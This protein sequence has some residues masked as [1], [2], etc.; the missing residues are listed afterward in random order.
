SILTFSIFGCKIK[1]EYSF[2]LILCF[3]LLLGAD[4]LLELLLCSIMHESGH[5]VALVLCGGGADSLTFSYYGLALK[6]SSLLSKGKEFL[7]LFSGPAVNLIL[8]LIFKNDI[9]LLLFVLNALPIFPLDGGRI[10]RLFLPKTSKV[11]SIILL[12]AVFVL[13]IF[14]MVHYKSFSLLLIAVYLLI[15]SINY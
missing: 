15:Y 13:S 14:M 12:V 3:S 7:V 9:N 6:Y 1:I 10:L 8:Y 2:V 4:D 11:V 5:L